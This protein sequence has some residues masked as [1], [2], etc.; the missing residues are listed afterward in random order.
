VNGLE[1]LDVYLD[2]EKVAV[3][4][5]AGGG[6]AALAY[7]PA[8]VATYGDGAVLLSLGLPVRE[9]TYP[10]VQTRP[11][12]DGLLPE[13][14]S[15]QAIAA[16]LR[17]DRAD[18]F[19][20]LRELGRDVAGALV[21][22]PAGE[23]PEAPVGSVRW[24]RDEEL[25]AEIVAL[26]YAPL[27]VRREGEVRLSLA[28][29]QPKLG[30]VRDADG[31]LGL[32]LNGHPTTH[33]LKPS[34]TARDRQGQLLFPELA[35]N[36][37]FCLRLAAHAGLSSAA[38]EIVRAV[39]DEPCVLV[40]RYDR[41]VDAGARVVRLHQEDACQAL[42]VPPERKYEEHG[43]PTLQQVSQLL[44]RY[45]REPIPDRYR[46]LDAQLLHVLVG[47]SDAHGKN[48]SFI[49]RDGAVGLAPL[50]DVVSTAVYP[51]HPRDLAMR[52]GGERF[53][54]D[55]SAASF[56]QAYEDCGLRA[57]LAR[58]RLPETI[59]RL[60]AAADAALADAERERWRTAIVDQV[61]DRVRTVGARMRAG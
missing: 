14:D 41:H 26:P 5:G 11:F 34:A 43:G 29:V 46:L 4:I 33:I 60:L 24:L 1:R 13:G 44:E 54:E 35:E 47:N 31:R 36:E 52:I 10:G 28:G 17:L 40:E 18:V 53:L 25:E 38:V 16:E 57:A 7:E 51:Q 21:I 3:L 6:Y 45:S 58:R 61:H 19:G 20:L 39:A 2:K 9:E 56:E 8:I 42:R 37:A 22:V 32:P 15:R 27:G 55:V 48:V 30:L 59:D 23:P 12:L 49:Y 50:Y